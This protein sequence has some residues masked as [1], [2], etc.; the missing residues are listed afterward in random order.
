MNAG[1]EWPGWYARGMPRLYGTF[2]GKFDGI[3]GMAMGTPGNEP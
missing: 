2:G 3:G 1:D